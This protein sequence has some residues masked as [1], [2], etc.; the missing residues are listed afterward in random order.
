MMCI[1][2]QQHHLKTLILM[3]SELTQLFE[4]NLLSIF[5]EALEMLSL[6]LQNK[7]LNYL[8]YGTRVNQS[9]LSMITVPNVSMRERKS[10]SS[11]LG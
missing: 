5:S 10:E 9:I 1:Y 11:P 2:L 7:Q 4:S 8:I 3:F 6:Y